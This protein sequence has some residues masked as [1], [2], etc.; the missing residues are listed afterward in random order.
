MIRVE[1]LYI[2][3]PYRFSQEV[4]DRDNINNYTLHLQ[5]RYSLFAERINEENGY[6]QVNLSPSQVLKDGIHYECFVMGISKELNDEIEKAL[7][8]HL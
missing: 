3:E 6:I 7:P 5:N 1:Y 8:S 4:F 2:G